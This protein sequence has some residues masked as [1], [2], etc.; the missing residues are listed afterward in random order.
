MPIVLAQVKNLALRAANF[1]KFP[2]FPHASLPEECRFQD[3]GLGWRRQ[4][5]EPNLCLLLL[6]PDR[7]LGSLPLPLKPAAAVGVSGSSDDWE[8]EVS[9]PRP[10]CSWQAASCSW[11]QQVFPIKKKKNRYTQ[12]VFLLL[13][14]DL[15]EVNQTCYPKP[16]GRTTETDACN[17]CNF[18][19]HKVRKLQRAET[20]RS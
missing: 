14:H 8:P 2:N 5:R 17:L 1:P 20:F 4:L 18:R 7:G 6:L 16:E 3:S 11:Q 19:V 13:S 12:I 9:S 15:N 10:S